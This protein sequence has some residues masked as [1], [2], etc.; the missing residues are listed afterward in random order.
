MMSTLLAILAI[1]LLA[2]TANGLKNISWA[3]DVDGWTFK[4]PNGWGL[5]NRSYLPATAPQG[6]L[7]EL[8]GEESA[9][10]TLTNGELKL[11]VR[12]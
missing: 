8:F 10:Y 7:L 11:P 1:S 3:D 12:R 4:G 5:P 6:T 2:L 9:K